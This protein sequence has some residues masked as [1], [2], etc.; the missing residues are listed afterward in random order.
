[1]RYEEISFLWNAK[2][3]DEKDFQDPEHI[4]GLLG[5]NVLEGGC[6]DSIQVHLSELYWVLC[7]SEGSHR[8]ETHRIDG[9]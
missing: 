7:V 5:K 9:I 6:Q 8:D 2:N 4:Y 3:L 1:M